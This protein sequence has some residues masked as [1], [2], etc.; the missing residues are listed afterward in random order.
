MDAAQMW[1]EEHGP[2]WRIRDEVAGKKTTIK[3]GLPNKTVA[4]EVMNGL[5]VDR[6][7][8][9]FINPQAGKILLSAF[10][11]TFWPSYEV[12]IK[13]SSRRSEWSRVKTHVI[14]QLGKY[15]LNEIDAG[16]V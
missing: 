3:S 2:T 7:R 14:P 6:A 5:K 15:R 10:I 16:I 1:V 11:D 13:P 9:T 8:G 12:T 4:K